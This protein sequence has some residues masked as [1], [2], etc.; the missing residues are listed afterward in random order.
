MFLVHPTLTKEE[1]NQ[2]KKSM[3]KVFT[4]ALKT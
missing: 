1:I 2:T 3:L 4:L